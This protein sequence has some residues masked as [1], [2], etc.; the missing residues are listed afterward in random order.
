MILNLVF[1]DV[2]PDGE[3][4]TRKIDISESFFQQLV[5]KSEEL[6]QSSDTLFDEVHYHFDDGYDSFLTRIEPHLEGIEKNRVLLAIYPETIGK[7]GYLSI[8]EVKSL[9]QKGYRVA[10]HGYSHVALAIEGQ[11]TRQGGEYRNRPFGR[12]EVLSSEE[13]RFQLEESKNILEEWFGHAVTEF[14][15]PFGNDNTHVRDMVKKYYDVIYVSERGL[16]TGEGVFRPRID[17]I[18]RR[19]FEETIEYMLSQK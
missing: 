2:R 12:S 7:K 14:V 3:R 19:S 15:T 17:V 18:N 11:E 16:D 1:H 10:S 8:D 4:L 6:A 13:V 9:E 5:K